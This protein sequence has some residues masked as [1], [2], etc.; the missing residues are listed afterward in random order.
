MSGPRDSL[1]RVPDLTRPPY[2]TVTDRLV[3]TA[4]ARGDL[5][6]LAALHTDPRV[7]THFPSGRHPDQAR[8]E[9]DLTEWRADWQRAGIGYWTAR[10]R[11][12]GAFVGVG[13]VRRRPA[14]VLN[15][16]YRIV[17]EQQGRGY[18]SE[19]ARAALDAAGRIVPG[20]P[21]TAFLLEH[22]TGSKATAERLGLTPVWRGPDAGNPDP[23]A[24]R[25]VY[26]DRPLD[27]AVLSELVRS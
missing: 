22:N 16:Y 18:A 8:T 26:A 1:P 13:G 14:G 21:V 10:G 6:E 24:V 11:D 2:R 4:V 20:V 9:S 12:D 19:L 7:W 25:L 15:L 17:P 23:E 3:L 5:D 27:D